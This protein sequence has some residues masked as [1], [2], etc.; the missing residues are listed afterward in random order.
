M[1]INYSVI[2]PAYN[3]EKYIEESIY[4]T[5]NQTIKP[6]EIIIIDDSS[7]DS[8]PEIV[9][10]IAKEQPE[11]RLIRNEQNLGVAQSRNKGLENIHG[12]YIAFLDADDLWKTEKMEKQLAFMEENQLALSFTSYQL[13]DSNGKSLHKVRKI[14]KNSSFAELLKHNYIGPSTAV[15]S[16]KIAQTIRFEKDFFHEDYIYFLSIL[17]DEK[18]VAGLDE[19]LVEY[20]VHDTNRN[21]NKLHA[22]QGRWAVYRNYLH[23]NVFQSIYYFCIYAFYGFIE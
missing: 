5:L 8:T 6:T 23:L 4:S 7:T 15:I 16:K 20:R 19:I 9:E 10:E 21:K 13:I 11:I 18:R 12:D 3:S 2:I 17:K 1:S 22:A 14:P